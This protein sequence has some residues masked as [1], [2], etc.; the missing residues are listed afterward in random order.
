VNLVERF[1]G[2]ARAAGFEVHRGIDPAELV[3]GRPEAEVGVS[4]A[5]YGLADTGSVVL[6]AGPDSPRSRSLL[7]PVHISVLAVDNVLPG[8]ADLFR[9]LGT[10]LPSEVAIVTGPSRSADIEQTLTIG[11]HGPGEV[12]VVLVD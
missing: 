11:V 9:E 6:L 10:D 1:E 3:A 8:L 12:H 2:S 4:Q 5:A 7:P